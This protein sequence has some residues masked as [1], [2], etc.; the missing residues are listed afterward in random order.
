MELNKIV[1]EIRDFLK[2]NANE[3]IVKK[4]S[5][6][7]KDGYDGYGIEQEIFIQK[8]EE[9][10]NKYKEKLSI[11]EFLEFGGML[12]SSGKYEE[13]ALAIQFLMGQKANLDKN[14]FNVI[15]DWLDKYVKNW[16]HTD[17]ICSELTPYFFEKNIVKLDDIKPWRFSQSQWK[18]RAVPV[19][20][21]KLMKR[22]KSPVQYL[23]LIDPMMMDKNRPVHQGLGWFLRETWKKYP[24][25]VESFLLK[26]KNTAPR[27]IFQYATEKM[28]K[29]DKERY[30]KSK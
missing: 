20:L 16:A 4:Y 29:Q 25:P 27:L 21:I 18:R 11:E 30:R 6:Y 22:D 3:A 13:G 26:W 9:W 12:F 1:K 28:T 7:F 15:G 8:K 19:T 2:K 10:L 5:R 17:Y 23:N 14:S 24:E